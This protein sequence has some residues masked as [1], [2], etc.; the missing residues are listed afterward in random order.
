MGELQEE[1]AYVPSSLGQRLWM[2]T[3]KTEGANRIEQVRDLEMPNEF[4]K[5]LARAYARV[6]GEAA[7]STMSQIQ[8]AFMR[9]RD[10]ANANVA[11]HE[12]F[13][14]AIERNQLRIF[15]FFDCTTRPEFHVLEVDTEGSECSAMPAR[16][17][18]SSNEHR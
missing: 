9:N 18:E 12:R 11:N 3:P 6:L 1:D 8:Q 10:I 17:L 15:L 4:R 13:Y 7:E 2:V 14:G 16:T 5:V